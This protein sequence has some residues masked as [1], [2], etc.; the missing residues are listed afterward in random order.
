MS[1][2]KIPISKE[3]LK[4]VKSNPATISVG[5]NG[6]TDGIIKEIKVTLKKNKIVKIKFQK[7]VLEL[8]IEYLKKKQFNVRTNKS[9]NSLERR[10]LRLSEI[11]SRIEKQIK[12]LKK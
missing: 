7:S 3:K 4:T 11:K 5:K 10:I 12:N 9:Y 1:S 2:K 8:G 6:I